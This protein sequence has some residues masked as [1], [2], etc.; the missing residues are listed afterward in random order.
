[1]EDLASAVSHLK[2]RADQNEEREME[3]RK[4]IARWLG[5]F[6][7]RV[8]NLSLLLNM[9]FETV[10]EIEE[11]TVTP[12]PLNAPCKPGFKKVTDGPLF[13]CLWTSTYAMSH[14]G[15]REDCK[16]KGAHLLTLTTYEKKKLLVKNN[17]TKSI[18]IGLNDQEYEGKF[19]WE[20]DNSVCDYSC[21][22]MIFLKGEPN[23][24]SNEDCVKYSPE[25]HGLNDVFCSDTEYFICEQPL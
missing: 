25:K 23:N 12:D 22:Q 24:V 4:R 16:D 1:M 18:W 9:Q 15:A 3:N 5:D 7:A 14:D 19:V 11:S 20:D 13:A 17:P 21:R 2:D 10:T 8:D 6:N